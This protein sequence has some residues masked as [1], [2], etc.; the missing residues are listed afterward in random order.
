[1]SVSSNE[2]A[3]R[4]FFSTRVSEHTPNVRKMR[5]YSKV[6]SK[7]KLIITGRKDE[8]STTPKAGARGGNYLKA[9]S[10]ES[11]PR[12]ENANSTYS[13]KKELQRLDSEFE[14]SSK[15]EDWIR[16]VL[17]PAR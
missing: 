11:K 4:S 5:K 17:A 1:M 12:K 14:R 8:R 16:K 13:L 10:R 9:H 2:G 6:E 3:K 7:V 15:E